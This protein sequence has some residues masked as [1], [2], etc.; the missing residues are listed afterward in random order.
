MQELNLF[1]IFTSKLTELNLGYF[2]TGSVASIVYGEPRLTH[3]I[4]IVLEISAINL[5]EFINAFPGEQFYIPPVEIIKNEINR[6]E[7][8][9]FNIIHS[10]SG[11]KADIFLLGNDKFQKWALENK[12]QIT[13]EDTILYIAPPEYVIIKKLEFY[14]EG[15]AQK[16]LTDIRSILSNSAD[17]INLELIEK[18]AAQFGVLDNWHKLKNNVS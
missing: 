12:K 9:H 10:E 14:K 16:H 7:R 15:G 17:I 18:Y 2:I 6:S 11:F 1:K 13:F 3:D 8:G 4:D 5:V